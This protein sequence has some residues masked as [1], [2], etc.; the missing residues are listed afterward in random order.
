M[1]GIT[2]QWACQPTLRS[3]LVNLLRPL[4]NDPIS[5]RRYS[6]AS[7]WVGCGHIVLRISFAE[8]LLMPL[9]TV[10]YFVCVYMC[11]VCGIFDCQLLL[12][13]CYPNGFVGCKN[14]SVAEKHRFLKMCKPIAA[15]PRDAHYSILLGAFYEDVLWYAKWFNLPKYTCS[16]C[17]Q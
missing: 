12:L 13:H 6:A 15:T 5:K 1:A 16:M 17:V 9:V 14:C 7:S 2:L 4:P 3:R 11:A 8:V 10:C